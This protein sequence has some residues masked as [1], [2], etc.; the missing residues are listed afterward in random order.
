MF[1]ENEDMSRFLDVLTS[2][3]PLER[4][5][6]ITWDFNNDDAEDRA[7]LLQQVAVE[8]GQVDLIIQVYKEAIA[9]LD[10]V[11]AGA[12]LRIDLGFFYLMVCDDAQ[13]TKEVTDEILDSR[14]RTLQ[15]AVTE[16]RPDDVL[17]SAIE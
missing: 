6:W 14:C 10:N 4:L 11:Q 1:S 5:A 16:V 9:Y 12:P 13:R 7:T 3:R 8:T 2:W 17:E 15:Y